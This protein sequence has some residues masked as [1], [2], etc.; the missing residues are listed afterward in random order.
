MLSPAFTKALVSNPEVKPSGC[1]N[2]KLHQLQRRVNSHY[3]AALAACGLKGTQYSLLSHVL[4]L[5]PLR[6]VE[7]AALLRMSPSTLSRNL[8]PLVAAGWIAVQP[9][10]D[11]RSHQLVVTPEGMNKRAQAQVLWLCAQQALNRQLGEGRVVAL[12]ALLD[13]C[14]LALESGPLS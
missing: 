13:D 3:D 6:S 9:G 7:L 5:G 8:K 1:T 12:H 10:A 11:G 2:L 14:L 4:K